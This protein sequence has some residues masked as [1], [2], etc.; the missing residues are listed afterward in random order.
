M[1]GDRPRDRVLCVAVLADS[2][3]LGHEALRPIAVVLALVSAWSAQR[4]GRWG[5]PA[6]ALAASVLIYQSGAMAYWLAI[7]IMSTGRDELRPRWRT[8]A[9]VLAVGVIVALGAFV[10]GRPEQQVAAR[11]SLSLELPTTM[12]WFVGRVLPHSLAPITLRTLPVL[13]GLSGLV[14]LAGL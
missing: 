10:A 6:T 14:L 11:K 8:H 13:A 5:W 3:G 12:S 4:T 7:A 2:R 9:T 1:G